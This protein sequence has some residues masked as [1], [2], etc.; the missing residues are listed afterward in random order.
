MSS[1]SGGRCGVMVPQRP[2]LPH[3]RETYFDQFLSEDPITFPSHS[4]RDGIALTDAM[5]ENFDNLVGMDDQMHTF[6]N[7]TDSAISLRLEVSSSSAD[8]EGT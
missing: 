7:Y 3:Y 6:V 1:D 4:G 8:Q 5:D 2:Y